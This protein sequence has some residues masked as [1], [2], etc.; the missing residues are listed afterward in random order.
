MNTV[1]KSHL[2]LKSCRNCRIMDQIKVGQLLINQHSNSQHET[3]ETERHQWAAIA[4][5]KIMPISQSSVE[6]VSKRPMRDEYESQQE[7]LDLFWQ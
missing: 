4:E 2:P 1:G 7:N 6:T 5:Y 3:K